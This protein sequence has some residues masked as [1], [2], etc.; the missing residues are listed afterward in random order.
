MTTD[1]R[2]GD[3]LSDFADLMRTQPDFRDDAPPADPEGRRRRARRVQLVVGIVALL[4]VGAPAGYA[5]WALNAPLA[6]P[7]AEYVAPSVPVV[8]PAEIVFPAEGDTALSIS[9]GDA[10]LDAG[11]SGIPEHS[12]TDEQ[13]SVASI[14]KLVTALVVLDAFPLADADDP[15]PTITF[16][17]AD[18]DLYD[19][20]YVRG[21]TVAAMPTGSSM[22]LHDALAT[23][24][25]PSASNYADAVSTWA[26]GSRSAFLDAARV[27]LAAHG[28]T[29]T[30]I[31]DPTGLDPGNTSTPSDLLRLGTLAAADP[32]IAR[33]AATP[34]L[35][36]EGPGSMVNTNSLLGAHGVTGLKTGNLGPGTFS[37][38][39][40]ASLSVGADE[41]LSVTGIMLGG[42]SRAAV[43]EG[44]GRLLES[45]RD[46]FH[47]VPVA[48][49]GQQVGTYSTP[50]GSEARAVVARDA[51]IFTWSDTP[52]SVA[53]DTTTPAT[54]TDGDVVGTLTWTAGASTATA[55]IVIEGAIAPPD[56]WWRLTHPDELG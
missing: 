27:W 32:T 17:R 5:A 11:A 19:Q 29:R 14:A 53:M 2:V 38:L 6:A 7:E 39:Y 51:R 31:V 55:D 4:V 56:E 49:R 54:Y 44:V 47:N 12:G 28:L 36:L 34:R 24:L 37:L 46:G 48:T 25:I 8:E 18:H 33:I 20:Y 10:Y 3:E 9:G 15:G 26:Y 30:N 40:T 50:W 43:D 35:W 16:S 52:I 13:R 22:S 21:A 45:I 41:P 42:M 1:D 23:M